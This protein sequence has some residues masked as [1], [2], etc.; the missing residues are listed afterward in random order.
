MKTRS[1][2]ACH[3]VDILDSSA[4]DG[5]S[6]AVF[7]KES[8]TV[9]TGLQNELDPGHKHQLCLDKYKQY[10]NHRGKTAVV[11]IDNLDVSVMFGY[12]DLK[13]RKIN[14]HNTVEWLPIPSGS[15]HKTSFSDRD[16]VEMITCKE[17]IFSDTSLFDTDDGF[18]NFFVKDGFLVQNRS[19]NCSQDKKKEKLN[20]YILGNVIRAETNQSNQHCNEC[21]SDSVIFV[22]DCHNLLDCPKEIKQSFDEL[23]SARKLYMDFQKY[24][25]EKV[26]FWNSDEILTHGKVISILVSSETKNKPTY[27]NVLWEERCDINNDWVPIQ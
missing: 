15:K 6:V 23:D 19:N 26:V 12:A 14:G 25:L 2:G 8:T 4:N 7:Q 24:F 27:L 11:S 18:N 9:L 10:M 17:R 1:T 13:Q 20:C 3:V 21:S 16:L 5:D 22:V